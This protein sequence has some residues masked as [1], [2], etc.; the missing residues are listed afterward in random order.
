M[1]VLLNDGK[2]ILFEDTKNRTGQ[3][4]GLDGGDLKPYAGGLTS[5]GFPSPA[6]DGKRIIMMHF[7]QGSAPEPTVFTIGE[8]DGKPALTAP[9]LRATP[10]WR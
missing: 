7:R 6:P 3:T 9:G 8:K 5:Y 1:P 4:C 2:T 10:A